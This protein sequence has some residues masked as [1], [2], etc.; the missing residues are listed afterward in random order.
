MLKILFLDDQNG[1][2][3]TCDPITITADQAL[4]EQVDRWGYGI[5]K[6]EEF[7]LSGAC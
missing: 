7:P 6:Y 3:Y 1:R 4:F 5:D 2:I